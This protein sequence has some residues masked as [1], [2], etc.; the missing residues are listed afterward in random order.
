MNNKLNYTKINGL[1]N[2]IKHDKLPRDRWGQILCV[3][4]LIVM[5]GFN[6]I[7]KPDEL[8]YMKA[9]LAEVVETQNAIDMMGLP[10]F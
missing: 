3:E 9:K 4:D 10:Q 1:L 7:L 6:E 2:V 8:E 5:Y